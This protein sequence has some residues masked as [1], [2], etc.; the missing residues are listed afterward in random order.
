MLIPMCNSTHER[1]QARFIHAKKARQLTDADRARAEAYCDA[2]GKALRDV[3]E[4]D[5]ERFEAAFEEVAKAHPLEDSVREAYAA[6]IL[7]KMADPLLL[8]HNC[9]F[10][11]PNAPWLAVMDDQSQFDSASPDQVRHHFSKWAMDELRRNWNKAHDIPEDGIIGTTGGRDYLYQAGPR[12][13]FCLLVDDA[14]H[15]VDSQSKGNSGATEIPAQPLIAAR[16]RNHYRIRKGKHGEDQPTGPLRSIAIR[17]VH[18][19]ARAAKSRGET[20]NL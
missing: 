6:E 10:L 20:M 8:L 15:D 13:N 7:N 11:D 16:N 12:Y 3:P 18:V 1:L 5:L 4:H 14:S 17:S 2:I 19:A 9:E